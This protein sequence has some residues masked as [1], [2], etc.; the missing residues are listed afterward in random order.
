M[1]PQ[2]PH[3]KQ[4]IAAGIGALLVI[5]L[6]STYVAASS[7]QKS[8]TATTASTP[9][10]TTTSTPAE[11]TNTPTATTTSTTYKDGTYSA[12]SSYYVPHGS[13]DI[14]V[15]ITVKS[16]VITDSAIVNSESDRES[17]AY[18][19]DF[20][21]EYKSYVVGKNIDGLQLSYVAGASDTTQGFN[22]ALSNIR[23]QAQA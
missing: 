5:V 23:T 8:S 19:E 12:S 10:T 11:T 21:S 14:K 9:T 4:K 13:E 7:N 15:T 3:N 18:Q 22:D 20:A 16:G 1:Y 2:K 17:A 6:L